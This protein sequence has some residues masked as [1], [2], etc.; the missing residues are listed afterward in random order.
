MTVPIETSGAIALVGSGEYLPQ[1]FEV[2]RHLIATVGGPEQTHAVLIPTASALEPGMP[3]RWNTLGLAHFQLLDVAA[4]PLLILQRDDASV[5]EV[6]DELRRA[7]FFYF[8]GG[9]PHQI[10][11]TWR[12]TPAWEVLTTRRSQGAVIAGC[13]A[14]AMMMGGVTISIRRAIGGALEWLPGLG[15][16]PELAIL[17]HFDRMRQRFSTEQFSTVL[18]TTPPGI[19]VVGVDEDTALV[20]IGTEWQVMGLQGVSVFDSDGAETRYMTGDSVPLPHSR[21]GDSFSGG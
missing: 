19:T 11:D 15:V 13:S 10:I 7:N 8:S 5:P 3:Q 12:D 20:R 9:N 6:I 21:G 2:D 4:V 16:V 14:G 18:R 1:M 17:P